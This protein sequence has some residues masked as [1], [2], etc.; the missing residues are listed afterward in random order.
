ML[1]LDPKYPNKA[2][3]WQD[4][5]KAGINSPLSNRA[6][7][8]QEGFHYRQFLYWKRKSV[9]QKILPIPESWSV[10]VATG[11]SGTSSPDYVKLREE[12]LGV[13]TY[14]V[15]RPIRRNLSIDSLACQIQFG[16]GLDPRSGE[17]FVMISTD[18]TQL[19]VLAFHQDGFLLRCKRLDRGKFCW[20]GHIEADGSTD[21]KASQGAFLTALLAKGGAQKPD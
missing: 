20:P 18:R 6:W 1:A 2:A 8:K 14:L 13:P 5:L 21:L 17:Q 15:L 3:M 16:L 9:Q 11:A 7:C 4:I 19:F 12:W 10:S